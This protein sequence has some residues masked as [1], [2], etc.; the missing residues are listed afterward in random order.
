MFTHFLSGIEELYENSNVIKQPMRYQGMTYYE[1]AEEKT[2][3]TENDVRQLSNA[4]LNQKHKAYCHWRENEF[5]KI[6][7]RSLVTYPKSN[8]YFETPVIDES[9]C[10]ATSKR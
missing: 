3:W 1:M 7:P 4:Y 8:G 9:Y 10:N 5:E 6:I 2:L